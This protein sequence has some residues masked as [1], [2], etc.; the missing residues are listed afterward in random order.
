MKL[1]VGLGNPG[2]RYEKT[3]HNVGFIILDAL[4]E[5][6]AG[7]DSVRKWK[8]DKK[9]NAQ[10]AE[11]YLASK[12]ILLAKPQ[13]FMNNSGDAVSLLATYYDIDPKQIL[14]IHDDKDI[15][16]GEVLYQ[17][18]RGHAGQNGVR[19]IIQMLG[20]KEFY[21]LRIGIKSPLLDRKETSE[22]VLGKFSISERVKLKQI[23]RSAIDETV[24]YIET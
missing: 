14:V 2:K 9:C 8:L 17:Y 5:Q 13:T 12:K 11:G 3:R 20:T 10:I 19:S 18:N 24:G 7:I 4:Y 21:R 15:D 22:F 16:F 23:I 6:L 1:I